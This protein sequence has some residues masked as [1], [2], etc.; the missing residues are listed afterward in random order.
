[1]M[2]MGLMDVPEIFMWMMNSLF[3]D[4]LDKGVVIFLDD[5]PIYSTTVE[6]HFNLLEKVFANLHKYKFIV[7]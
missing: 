7:S 3:M 4:I 2:P 1:M 6:E 5:I